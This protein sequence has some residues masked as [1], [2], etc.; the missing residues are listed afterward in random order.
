MERDALTLWFARRHP[1]A[2]WLAKLLALVVS[3]YA[4][5]RPRISAGRLVI[6]GK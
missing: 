1:N 6:D 5:I 2:P 3:A 4:L